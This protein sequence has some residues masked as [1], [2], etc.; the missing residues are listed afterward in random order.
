MRAL[1]FTGPGVMEL[2]DVAQPVAEEGS[3]LLDVRATGICGSELHG[4]RS[5]GLRVPPLVMGHE[6]AGTTADGRRVVVNPLTSCGAC[7]LCRAGRP[8][9]CPD[10]V[11][12]GVHRAG[13]FAERVAV[14]VRSLHELPHDMPWETAAMIEPLA[15]AVHAWRHLDLSGGERIAIIG[16]G[17]IGLVSL[18][19]ARRCG[20]E[21]PTVVDRSEYRLALAERLGATTCGAELAGEY[22]VVLDAVGAGETRRAAVRHVRPG[23]STVWVGLAQS[24][25]TID[26]NDIVRSE[27]RVLGSFGYTPEDFVEALA[28]APDLDLGWVTPIPFEESQQTFMA[29]AEGASDPV[30]AVIR[31]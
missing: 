25:A 31:L 11:L 8:Q 5:V 24:E 21:A 29:L 13:G 7:A 15:N 9:T 16:A 27:K 10:R 20:L 28:A 17:A 14:P 19:W 4:F 3:I 6:F 26:G 30:K 12:L 2:Q 1:V 22:D 18:L 23:G